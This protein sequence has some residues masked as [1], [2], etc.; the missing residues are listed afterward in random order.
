MNNNTLIGIDFSINKPA[1][2]IL[3]NGN[4]YF[5]GWP[6]NLSKK[7]IDIYRNANVNIIERT[8]EKIISKDVSE[9][10]RF[11]ISNSQYLSEVMFNTLKSFLH[12]NTYIAFEGLSYGSSGNVALQLGGY[13]YMLMSKLSSK[14]PLKNMFT[15]SPITAKKTANCAGRGKTKNDIIDSFIKTAHCSVLRDSIR[16]NKNK[17]MKRGVK[18]YITNLDDY[19]DSYFILET[20]REKELV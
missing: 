5:Y 6:Y 4:Y 16:E 2:C 10:M 9:K 3:D 8:D 20:L 18:N 14:V 15:Y 19:V 11:E 13:K 1:A 12:I 17:F 7:L